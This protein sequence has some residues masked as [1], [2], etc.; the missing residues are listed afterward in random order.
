MPVSEFD[1]QIQKMIMR[2]PENVSLVQMNF[3][4]THDVPRFLSYCNGDRRKMELAYFYLFMGYG[5]P[6]VFYG[7]ECYIEGETE[8]AYR[9]PMP[10]KNK[11]NCYELFQKYAS[12][13]RAHSAIRN[14]SYQSVLCED[15]KG[16]YLFLRQNE[17][18]QVLVIINNSDVEQD[19]DEETWNIVEK[20]L[21]CKIKEKQKRV[22]AMK[23]MICV[24]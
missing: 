4:D 10:W 22:P 6:S 21:F 11:D 9:S 5:I 18:E 2:Y 7:D 23:G 14:G 19:L 8:N 12:I 1:A 13:R 15:G 3:L 20:K 16:L 17:E 24:I